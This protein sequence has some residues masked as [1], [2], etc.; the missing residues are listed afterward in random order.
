MMQAVL[1]D[2]EHPDWNVNETEDPTIAGIRMK[3]YTVKVPFTGY[4]TVE[5]DSETENEA[6]A[7]ALDLSVEVEITNANDLL[8]YPEV[9][10]WATCKQIVAGNV[11]YG[12]LNRLNVEE[13]E[14]EDED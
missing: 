13:D 5:I 12:V 9:T 3:R 10:Q 2:G 11:F 1:I 4:Y 7:Q 14:L 8:V 6:V